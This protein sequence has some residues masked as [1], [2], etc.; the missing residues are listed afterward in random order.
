[1]SS[2][3]SSGTKRGRESE[4]GQIEPV[5]KVQQP[6]IEPITEE[7]LAKYM[8]EH[9]EDYN[10]LNDQKSYNTLIGAINSAIE[11]MTTGKSHKFETTYDINKEFPGKKPGIAHLF[12][13][14]FSRFKGLSFTTKGSRSG[15]PSPTIVSKLKIGFN[16]KPYIVI[17]VPFELFKG[18]GPI[19]FA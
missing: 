10:K 17:Q 2:E 1:M 16:E 4:T 8:T 13:Y 18:G 9:N 19:T 6:C 14:V 7:E 12:K 15:A 5:A 11:G 3:E